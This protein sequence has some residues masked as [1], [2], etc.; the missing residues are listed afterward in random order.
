M[1]QAECSASNLAGAGMAVASQVG[2]IFTGTI[3]LG[4]LATLAAIPEVLA[5]QSPTL[6]KPDLTKAVP[7]VQG[8]R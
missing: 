8:D 7:L 4:N 6:H 2:D 1:V 5:I 3:A